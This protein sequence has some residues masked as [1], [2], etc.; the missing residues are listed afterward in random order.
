MIKA[1]LILISVSVLGLAS[2]LSLTALGRERDP[3]TECEA[4]RKAAFDNPQ[5]A[6][7]LYVMLV[8]DRHGLKASPRQADF[9]LIMA[10]NEGFPPAMMEL[11]RRLLEG[12]GMERQQAVAYELLFAAQAA[13]QA[14]GELLTRAELGL[15]KYMVDAVRAGGGQSIPTFAYTDGLDRLSQPACEKAS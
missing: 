13:G 6:Y 5:A 1:W 9:W 11:G 7:E 3:V 14:V 15:P 10:S 8:S 2:T 4:L 12:D